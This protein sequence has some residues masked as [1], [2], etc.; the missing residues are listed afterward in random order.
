VNAVDVKTRIMNLVIKRCERKHEHNFMVLHIRSNPSQ[1]NI[2]TTVAIMVGL[3]GVSVSVLFLGW[4][5]GPKSTS[6]GE[7]EAIDVFPGSWN[8][9]FHV[10]LFHLH[11]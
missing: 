4:R 10:L 6:G 11:L 9:N 5:F 1:N 7:P 8:F 3:L 2:C